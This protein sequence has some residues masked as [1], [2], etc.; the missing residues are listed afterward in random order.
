MWSARLLAE[1]PEAI[2]R[3]HS[4]YLEAGARCI[5]SSSYQASIPGFMDL[6]FDRQTSEDYILNTVLLA[7]LAINRQ[8]ETNAENLK[9]LIAASIGPYGAYLADG[10]EYRGDYDIPDAELMVFHRE[11]IEL[12]D[13]TNAD[14]LAC[15]TIPSLQEARVLSDILRSTKKPAW[16]TFSCKDGEHINDGSPI[17]EAVSLFTHHPNVFA[18]G[19]N[20]TAPKFISQLIGNIK[21]TSGD[22]KVVVYPNSGEAYNAQTKTW[23]GLSD[24]DSFSKMAQEWLQLGVD[25]IGGCC[26]IGPEHIASLRNIL[27][28]SNNS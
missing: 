15:E 28:E 17:S 14:F 2:I 26:R 1:D 23:I 24:P 22:K 16:V 21:T 10:S 20:C 19:I 13:Q 27:L 12:L 3:A 9:P 11:R 7:E 5:I 25:I 18:V 6:G 8:A 4:S